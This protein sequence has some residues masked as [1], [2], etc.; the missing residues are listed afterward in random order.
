MI[1]VEST[2][3]AI[4]ERTPVD[5][6]ELLAGHI[7]RTMRFERASVDQFEVKFN[8]RTIH[9]NGLIRRERLG[10]LEHLEL[11]SYRPKNGPVD[12]ISELTYILRSQ[13][14]V[15]VK[16]DKPFERRIRLFQ[17]DRG[18]WLLIHQSPGWDEL[19]EKGA[20]S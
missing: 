8:S 9:R 14:P 5:L 7:G 12:E 18:S 6:Q 3:S 16:S 15:V 13:D 1:E 2:A 19:I 11:S 17:E 10:V 4:A 20:N